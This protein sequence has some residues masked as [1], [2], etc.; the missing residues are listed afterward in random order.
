LTLRR[1][2]RDRHAVWSVI[3]YV[4]GGP[5]MHLR[6]RVDLEESERQQLEEIVAGGIRAVRRVKRAQIL[7][8]AAAGE[9]DA[10][11]ATMVRG[12]RRSTA[13]NGG[14]SRRVSRRRYPRIRGRA[15]NASSPGVRRR[16]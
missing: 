1:G 12:R 9:R 16:C 10:T 3:R 15:A 13:R 14:S 11:I 8:A 2:E 5:A 4:A 6:Y 7:L